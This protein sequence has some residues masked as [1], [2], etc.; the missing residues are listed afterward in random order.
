MT[1]AKEAKEGNPLRAYFLGNQGLKTDKWDNYFDVYHRHLRALRDAARPDNKIVMLE[2]GTYQ[3][4]SLSM[5][6]NYFGRECCEIYGMDFDASCKN[7][8]Q[9][10][11]GIHIL[12]G[13]QSNPG[14]LQRAMHE[15]PAPHIILDD[16]GHRPEQQITSFQTLWPWVRAGGVYMCE[17]L[18]TSY[19][20]EFG[21]GHGVCGSGTFMEHL[22]GRL[23]TIT[24]WNRDTDKW[25]D[26]IHLYESIVVFDKTASLRTHPHRQVTGTIDGRFPPTPTPAP[27][28]ARQEPSPDV[29]VSPDAATDVAYVSPA[30]APMNATEVAES[31]KPKSA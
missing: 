2:I 8:E 11:L 23:D 15:M 17:D 10:G 9:H 22:R 19:M 21:G 29:Q 28:A 25:L 1:E 6:Q 12:I 14:D 3:G 30:I 26:S 13:D 31:S 24:F 5:W 18:H 27:P 7:V 20:P 4:G 16:G